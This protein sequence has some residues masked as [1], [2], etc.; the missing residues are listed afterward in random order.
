MNDNLLLFND[1]MMQSKEKPIPS[2]AHEEA[3]TA[4]E[5]V[6]R[7]LCEMFKHATMD[8]ASDF[9]HRWIHKSHLEMNTLQLQQ[10]QHLQA[11]EQE[12]VQQSQIAEISKHKVQLGIEMLS[13]EREKAATEIEKLKESAS[14]DIECMTSLFLMTFEKYCNNQDCLQ[15]QQKL[16]AKEKLQLECQHRLDKEKDDHIKAFAANAKKELSS[17]RST[18][19][20]LAKIV[21]DCQEQYETQLKMGQMS[22]FGLIEDLKREHDAHIEENSSHFR[23]SLHEK[24]NELGNLNRSVEEKDACVVILSEKLTIQETQL[25]Q[26]RQKNDQ[27]D[28]LLAEMKEGLCFAQNQIQELLM[29]VTILTHEKSALLQSLDQECDTTAKLKR[30][31]VVMEENFRRIDKDNDHLRILNETQDRNMINMQT[32]LNKELEIRSQIETDREKQRLET[33]ALQL[34]RDKLR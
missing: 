21:K 28:L 19:V 2:C 30:E 8:V 18:I 20:W 17:C 1:A 32:A 11:I 26:A 4:T 5:E 16:M 34:T 10:R 22:I 13:E 6:C 12:R 23:R 7:F 3:T 9:L 15:F 27:D 24:D 31:A 29:K 33:D 14:I 25:V